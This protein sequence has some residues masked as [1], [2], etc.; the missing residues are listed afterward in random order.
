MRPR[1]GG[2]RRP[3]CQNRNTLWIEHARPSGSPVAPHSPGDQARLWIIALPV[4]R[5]PMGPWLVPGTHGSPC[6]L[7]HSRGGSPFVR[8]RQGGTRHL[9]CESSRD[10]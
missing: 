1:R 2:N 8:P 3:A 7:S 10:H 6:L 9:V 4:P 5:N